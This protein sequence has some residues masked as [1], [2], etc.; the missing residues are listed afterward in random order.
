MV[1]EAAYCPFCSEPT[2][3]YVPLCSEPTIE[4]VPVR[5]KRSYSETLR[6]LV[7]RKKHWDTGFG[8]VCGL[9]TVGG[10]LLV[11][12]LCILLNI[13]MVYSLI[14]LFAAFVIPLIFGRSF[15]FRCPRCDK[16]L[17]PFAMQGNSVGID[18]DIRFCPFCGLDLD[19]KIDP[20]SY[21]PTECVERESVQGEL[22]IKN[23]AIQLPHGKQKAGTDIQLPPG[24]EGTEKAK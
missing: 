20:Q 2:I 22:E 24:K 5:L 23:M 1:A 8:L 14:T 10:Y 15:T 9:L 11:I 6:T 12:L 16:D 17:V 7:K 3:E 19:E 13:S 18:Q 21:E 4:H